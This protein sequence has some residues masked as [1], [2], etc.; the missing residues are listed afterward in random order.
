MVYLDKYLNTILKKIYTSQ[1]L[2]KLLYYDIPNPTSMP[3]FSD[4][5]ILFT[6]FSNKRIFTTPF[7]VENQDAQ[8]SSLFISI[9][10]GDLDRGNVFYEDIKVEFI[11]ICNNRLWEIYSTDPTETA[12][13]P[14]AIL[15]ELSLLFNRTENVGIGKNNFSYIRKIYPNQFFAGYSMCFSGKTFV[16]NI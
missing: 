3:D 9:N 10:D 8:K 16:S 5:S 12:L 7:S 1:N 15:H 6:D 11:V 2:C 14:N 4:T 13:R